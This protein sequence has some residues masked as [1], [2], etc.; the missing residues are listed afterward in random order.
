MLHGS[1]SL[2]FKDTIHNF[3]SH[4]DGGPGHAETRHY[5]K[6]KIKVCGPAEASPQAAQIEVCP[7]VE[8]RV[9]L[10]VNLHITLRGSLRHCLGANSLRKSPRG[11]QGRMNTEPQ[12]PTESFV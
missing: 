3:T 2:N 7:C 5:F 6:F 1:H 4:G 10:P 9:L 8:R 12:Q 11:K